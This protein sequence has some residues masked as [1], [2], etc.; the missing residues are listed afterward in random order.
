[1]NKWICFLVILSTI[2]YSKLRCDLYDK[3]SCKYTEGLSYLKTENDDIYFSYLLADNDKILV[4]DNIDKKIPLA[5][6]TKMMTAIVVM[7]NVKNLDDKVCITKEVSQIPYGVKLKENEEYTVYDLLRLMLIRS[8]NAAAKALQDY[9]SP[10]FIDLMNKKAKEIGLK[11]TTYFT[12]Y[13]LPPKYTN[14]GMDVG[15]ARD[16]YVLSKYLIN[17]YP[18]LKDIVSRKYDEVGDKKI[19]NTNNL[20]GVI[21][22]V[23]GIKTGFHNASKYNIC[24]YYN[25]NQKELY[26]IILGSD[27]PSHRIDLTRAVFKEL[28]GLK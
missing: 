13:G 19:K 28:G 10:N 7:D 24:I 17:N 27:K 25:N 15:S 5:S 18:I 20:L 8:T 4:G 12:S 14:T 16:M 23:K 26:E 9:V 6:L 11:D 22:N 2:S 21:E 3:N 1:M